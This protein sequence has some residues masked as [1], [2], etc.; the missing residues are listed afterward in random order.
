MLSFVFNKQ[1][2]VGLKSRL[3][4]FGAFHQNRANQNCIPITD[5]IYIA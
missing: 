2:K 1:I 3:I 4:Y 5:F